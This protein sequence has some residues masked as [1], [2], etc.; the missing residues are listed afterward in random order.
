MG[1]PQTVHVGT[2][3]FG[4]PTMQQSTPGRLVGAGLGSHDVTVEMQ[5]TPTAA[6]IKLDA[7]DVIGA[8]RLVTPGT[9]ACR[10]ADAV[11]SDAI[12][13]RK[14]TGGDLGV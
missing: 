5:Q 8:E 9:D 1:F 6:G 12:S 4:S 11:H 2:G 10:I 14:D 3:F 13:R 7:G